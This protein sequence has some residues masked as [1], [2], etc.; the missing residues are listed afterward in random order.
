MKPAITFF[1]IASISFLA[2]QSSK[3][4]SRLSVDVG[5]VRG[6]GILVPVA[7]YESSKWS[8]I[9]DQPEK[10]DRS[11]R[12][13][14]WWVYDTD[15]HPKQLQLGPFVRFDP[16]NHSG[17]GYVSSYAAMKGFKPSGFYAVAF[18]ATSDSLK[19]TRFESQSVASI[20]KVFRSVIDSVFAAKEGKYVTTL[21]KDQHYYPTD[22]YVR[23][24]IPIQYKLYV[25]ALDHSPKKSE[26]AYFTATRS[27]PD[28]N[29]ATVSKLSGWL[30][31]DRINC[32]PANLIFETDDCDGKM[33]SPTFMP[34][35]FFSLDNRDYVLSAVFGWESD[36]FQVFEHT[37][38]GFTPQLPDE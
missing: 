25:A 15:P 4:L 16:G 24:N 32:S 38:S 5:I 22:K 19:I 37:N 23:S 21:P 26:I 12:N 2:N 6:D 10:W 34:Y 8:T 27:Y 11:R 7:R 9:L 28:K 31:F 13:R 18:A 14:P 35:V 29:C 3:Q 36:S 17:S 1:V 30:V 20:S 33:F